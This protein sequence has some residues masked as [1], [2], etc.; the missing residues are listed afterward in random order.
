M[1]PGA[2]HDID[3]HDS[4]Q[5]LALLQVNQV[6]RRMKAGDRLEIRGSDPGTFNALI[7]LLP[8]TRFTIL[9]A[10]REPDAYRIQLVRNLTTG[11]APG[12][13]DDDA[14]KPRED[15]LKGG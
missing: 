7:R 13:Q 6:L 11:P 3:L 15:A 2:Q 12:A 10:E 14:G 9:E 1:S 8:E 4:L 5:P